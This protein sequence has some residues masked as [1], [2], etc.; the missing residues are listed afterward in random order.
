MRVSS[1]AVVLGLSSLAHA[2][3]LRPL[4]VRHGPLSSKRQEPTPGDT[5][6]I[7]APACDYYQCSVKYST[8][9][10]VTVNWLNAP[11]NGDV[12]VALMTGNNEKVAYNITTAPPTLPTN[13]CDSDSGLGVLVSGRTCGR[14]EFNMP[15]YVETGNY[16]FRI[17][18]LPP[19][20]YQDTYTDVIL[21]KK[22][23][24]DVKF[25]LLPIKGADGE[26]FTPSGTGYP[27]PS[28]ATS[29]S[30]SKPSADGNNSSTSVSASTSTTKTTA[31]SGAG[32]S[33]ITT[34][35]HPTSPTGTSPSGSKAMV[36][37]PAQL[38]P[39]ALSMASAAMAAAWFGIM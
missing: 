10:L 21:V 38:L 32:T 5:L 31:V 25:E 23:K 28:T 27:S 33:N 15:S 12:Q 3:G 22:A 37:S 14:V 34:S 9:D 29:T 19:A 18:S 20:P 2:H 8:G 6:Y 35:P 11:E 13:F 16:S 7:N 36:G 17:T 4:G 1:L 24:G 39:L 26:M 30:A